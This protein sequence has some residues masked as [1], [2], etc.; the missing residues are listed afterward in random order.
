MKK[1]VIKMLAIALALTSL[2]GLMTAFADNGDG[3][4]GG[5]NN[6]L[7]LEASSVQNGAKDVPT[8]CEITLTFSKNVVNFTVKENNMACFSVTDSDG[9][10][11][12]TQVIMGDD[13]VD[14]DVK[15]IVVVKPAGLKEGGTYSLRIDGALTSKSGVSL[16]DDIVITFTTAGGAAPSEGSGR[17]GIA[18]KVAAAIGV[19]AAAGAII[20]V[21]MKSHK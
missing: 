11:V 4:G 10:P 12:E 16:G 7:T 21:A 19:A 18:G 15:R 8:D 9:G 14:P 5:S 1:S 17:T 3:S 2:C 20:I 6:P 13:Q